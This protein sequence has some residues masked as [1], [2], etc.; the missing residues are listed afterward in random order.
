MGMGGSNSKFLGLQN[1]II[2]QGLLTSTANHFGNAR[3]PGPK[4]NICNLDLLKLQRLEKMANI[5]P[6]NSG[7]KM[8]ICYGIKWKI[9]SNQQ[10]GHEQITDWDTYKTDCSQF[11]DIKGK[12]SYH[13]AEAKN[14][15][16]CPKTSKQL[17]EAHHPM[18]NSCVEMLMGH[19]NLYS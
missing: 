2:F 3:A 6:P 17:H 9:T 5:F 7:W 10:N 19:N 15:S 14:P 1:V 11:D 13:R 16:N 18:K 4:K 8:V 12:Y